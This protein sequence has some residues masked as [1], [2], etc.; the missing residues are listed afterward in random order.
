MVQ[1]GDELIRK[2][3][4]LLFDIK[5]SQILAVGEARGNKIADV[6][7]SEL[8][9][10]DTHELVVSLDDESKGVVVGGSFVLFVLLFLVL[11]FLFFYGVLF[12]W[13]FCLLHPV[14]FFGLVLCGAQNETM[15]KIRFDDVEIVFGA[16]ETNYG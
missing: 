6:E 2:M 4:F 8:V 7:K 1:T 5:G 3:S 13:V 9:C 15:K 14:F 11:F 10:T 16:V 12:R